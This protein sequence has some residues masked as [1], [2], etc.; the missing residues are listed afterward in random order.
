M[1]AHIR[2]PHRSLAL[3]VERRVPI[4][5]LLGCSAA[6]LAACAGATANPVVGTW[7]GNL[8]YDGTHQPITLRLAVEKDSLVAYLSQPEM[9]FYDLGPGPVEQH[10]DTFVTP[11]MTF[12]LAPGHRSIAGT[13]S[14]DGNDLT[15]AL[16]RGKEAP[17]PPAA[18]AA[19]GR[20]ATPAWTFKT[21]GAIWSSPALSDG[22]VYFG[23]NDSA[24]YALHA[25]RGTLIWRTRT[26]GWV[27]GPPAVSGPSLFVL[28]DDG[29]LYK[30]DR[31]TGQ[32]TWTF[33][34]HGGGVH[35]AMPHPPDDLAY[36]YL[37]SAPTIAAGVVYVGSAGHRL[38]AVDAA[39]GR[40]RWH[41]ETG[42]IVRSTPAVDAG[43]VI[44]GSRDH[45]IYAVDAGT[46]A[47]VWKRDTQREV[48]S[49][50]L[51]DHGTAYIGSRC[52]DLFA[53]DA[54][55]GAVRWKSFY[56]TSWVESSARMHDGIL[57]IGSSDYQQLLALDP[58]TGKQIW[59][60]DT[61]GSAW[62]TPAVTDSMV[63]IGAVGLPHLTYINHH[64]A[65]FAVHR[66]TGTVAWRFP[67]VAGPTDQTY[68]VASS[69][70]TDGR[71]VYF[72]GLDGTFYAFPAGG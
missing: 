8:T 32:I 61:D 71:L 28:S 57:Y 9:K 38:Y 35:R 48:V 54:A 14:F 13:M 44:F 45:F 56:W 43:R 70:A 58:A 10:G 26:R 23:S 11:P 20:V 46:G 4:R 40:E 66:A 25:D 55:T 34:T 42:D 65:F 41:F 59:H 60:F 62:S 64:G 7:T 67:M 30:L 16:T 47:L 69:P 22:T 68:G 19:S 39:S 37:A 6:A 33:D 17:H 3:F 21:A 50:A 36:D 52:S 1:R 29:L 18:A 53:L 15:F 27:M 51:I 31:R 72:G 5:W 49:S 12:H 63:Y 24:I 2:L